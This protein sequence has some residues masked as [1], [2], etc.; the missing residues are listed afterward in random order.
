MDRCGP[1]RRCRADRYALPFNANAHNGGTSMT[2]Q[3]QRL[4]ERWQHSIIMYT[5]AVH[6]RGRQ[7]FPIA[8]LREYMTP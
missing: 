7:A 4:S 6:A 5:T 1:Q 3:R 8:I 2:R